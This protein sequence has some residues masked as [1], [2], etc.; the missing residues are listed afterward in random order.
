MLGTVSIEPW[1][2]TNGV[3]TVPLDFGA[4]A[5]DGGPRYLQVWTKRAAGTNDFVIRYEVLR[6]VLSWPAS[7]TGFVL[8]SAGS[9]PAVTWSQVS[10]GVSL[11]GD[12]WEVVMPPANAAQFF[13]LRKP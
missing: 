4:S 9:F 2:V 12:T 5:F 6:V 11:N 8:E 7:F 3:F 13:R 1:P 10:F